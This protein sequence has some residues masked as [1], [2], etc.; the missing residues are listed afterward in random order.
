MSCC[1]MPM[2]AAKMAVAAPMM[3]TTV[4][5]VGRA[6]EERVAARDHVDAGGDHGGGVDERGDGRGA[7]HRVGQPD[8]EGDLRGLAGGA[9]DEQ[10]GDGGEEA[11]VPLGMLR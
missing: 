4:S 8:V 11:A 6:V 5:A 2:E 10:Q 9:E 3:A 7:F 1:T